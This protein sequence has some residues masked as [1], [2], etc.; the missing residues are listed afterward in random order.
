MSEVEQRVAAMQRSRF[1]LP[2][3]SWVT[4]G[5]VMAFLVVWPLVSQRAGEGAAGWLKRG[6][7][8]VEEYARKAATPLFDRLLP[9]LK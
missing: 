1:A 2:A 8:M 9:K 7:G 4:G 6:M 5:T 3:L